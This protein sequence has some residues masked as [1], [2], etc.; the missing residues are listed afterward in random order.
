MAAFGRIGGGVQGWRQ[1][2]SSVARA[3]IQVA[4]AGT[5]IILSVLSQWEDTNLK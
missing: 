3:I 5:L 1:E 2:D 4:K